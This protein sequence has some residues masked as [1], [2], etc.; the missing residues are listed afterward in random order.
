MVHGDLGLLLLQI[1]TMLTVGL[2]CGHTV[3]YGLRQP[4]V[5]GEIIGGILLGPAVFGAMMPGAY[6]WLFPADGISAPVR[7]AIIKL[8]ML[9]FLF[10][11]GLHINLTCLS[12]NRLSLALTSLGG[13]ALPFAL[14]AA[15]VYLFPQVW[16]PLF[17]SRTLLL[18]MFV[19]TAL[20]ISSLPVITRV[21]IDLELLKDEVGVLITAA[22]TV[23]DLIGWLL[24][25]AI[26]S[27]FVSSVTPAASMWT[28]GAI[29]LG[30]SI[31]VVS[32]GRWVRPGAI[33]FVHECLRPTTVATIYAILLLGMAAAAEAIHIHSALGAFIAGV[34]LAHS[35]PSKDNRTRDSMFQFAVGVFAPIYFVSIALKV[36]FSNNFDLSLVLLVLLIAMVGKVCGA[37]LGAWLG[38]VAWRRALAIG[39]GMNARGAMEIILASVA[40]ESGLIDERVFV[41]LVIMALVTTMLG[42]PM[43]QWLL[44]P[45]YK[46]SVGGR[47]E[48]APESITR[49][50]RRGMESR[51]RN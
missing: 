19:G 40:L 15:S 32:F 51:R 1:L 23:N 4:I 43:M 46:G 27:A 20:S 26:L 33:S 41:A 39:F 21:L 34:A 13:I 30:F 42:G 3:H 44:R 8:G 24:F 29:V 17:E 45:G 22:A 10:A 31:L 50:R 12:S 38:G 14:G 36:D 48:F 7:E 28:Y 9:V 49:E 35:A 11:A 6:E 37:G 18:A 25:A 2:V 5:T 16:G 47:P